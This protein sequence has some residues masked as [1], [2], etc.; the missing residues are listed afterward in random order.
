VICKVKDK[1]VKCVV[2]A[3][4]KRHHLRWS[5]MQGGHSVSHGS[6]SAARLQRILNHAPSGHYVLRI[7]G[8]GGERI[9]IG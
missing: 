3:V 6:T 4:N 8:Q 5:L 1:K 9:Q 2:K 7:A